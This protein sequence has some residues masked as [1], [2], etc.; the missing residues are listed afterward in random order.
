MSRNGFSVYQF[1]PS[2]TVAVWTMPSVDTAVEQ[3][4]DCVGS[5]NQRV[6]LTNGDAF[7]EWTMEQGI[8]GDRY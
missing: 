6:V 4:A 2:G 3:F 1:F 7:V 5:P 8:R